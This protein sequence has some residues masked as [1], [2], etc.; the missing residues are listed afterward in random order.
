MMGATTRS[1]TI[2]SGTQHKAL[3]TECPYAEYPHAEYRKSA[4][5]TECHGPL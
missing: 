2:K 3:N 4:H 5:N 1:I